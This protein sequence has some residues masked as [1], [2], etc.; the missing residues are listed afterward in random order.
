MKTLK[1]TM[2]G[3]YYIEIP[4]EIIRITGLKEGDQIDVRTG[5]D[6]SPRSKDIVL[7]K[8]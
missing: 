4:Q 6:I 5:G 3:V 1:R 2:K 8:K 7:M